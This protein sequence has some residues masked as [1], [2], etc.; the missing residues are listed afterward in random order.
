M[1][2]RVV[3]TKVVIVYQQQRLRLLVY[4]VGLLAAGTVPG[5]LRYLRQLTLDEAEVDLRLQ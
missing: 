5:A 2:G 1:V 3:V 4:L